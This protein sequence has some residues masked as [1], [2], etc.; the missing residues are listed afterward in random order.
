[1]IYKAFSLDYVFNRP[2]MPTW[3]RYLTVTCVVSLGL[4]LL[5]LFDV[6][7]FFSHVSFTSPVLKRE[8]SLD[9]FYFNVFR[10]FERM[11]VLNLRGVDVRDSCSVL[12]RAL[13]LSWTYRKSGNVSA[14]ATANKLVEETVYLLKRDVE[15][16]NRNLDQLRVI[17]SLCVAVLPPLIF[18]LAVIVTPRVYYRFKLWYLSSFEVVPSGRSSSEEERRVCKSKIMDEEVTAVVLALIIVASVFAVAY[19]VN[20]SRVAEPFS[21]IGLLG[22]NKKIGNYPTHVHP[23]EKF[24]LWVYVHDY[25]GHVMLYRIYVK[26]GNR[27]TFINSTIPAKAPI[28]DYFD[29]C[30]THN[31]SM[32]IPVYLSINKTG[33]YKLIFELWYYDPSTRKFRYK[34]LWTHLYINVTR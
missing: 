19:I 11:Y 25:E 31:E 6:F 10:V 7:G 21:A 24:L 15:R 3:L 5:F 27:S 13:N 2:S 12:N 23:G 33:S 17:V 4:C 28:I 22:P 9:S 30:L 34:G 16:Y 18:I 8:I 26:L 14:L 20:K 32:L 1:L 29:L